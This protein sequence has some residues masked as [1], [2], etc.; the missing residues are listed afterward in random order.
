MA[1]A[2]PPKQISLVR[3]QFPL[4]SWATSL[5]NAVNQFSRE[6]VQSLSKSAKVYRVLSFSTGA[7]PLASFP[8]DL[9]VDFVPVEVRVAM[10]LSGTPIGAVS[11]VAVPIM[12][13]G[14]VLRVINVTGLAANSTYSLRLA[15]E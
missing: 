5:V 15:L 6:V 14:Q 2:P 13:D 10:V 4:E 7:D 8:I 9:Q 1:D 11:V 3:A 12:G